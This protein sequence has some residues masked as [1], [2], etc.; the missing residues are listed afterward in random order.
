MT[1]T[2]SRLMAFLTVVAV[3][4]VGVAIGVAVDRSLLR[5]QSDM[6]RERRGGEGGSPFGMMGESQDTAA[7]NRMRGHIVKRLTDDLTLTPAQAQQVDA[8]FATRERQ[9]D[10]LRARVGPRLDSLRDG[11]RLA[12]D[13]VLSPSQ[14]VKAAER[15]AKWQERRRRGGGD[16]ERHSRDER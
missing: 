16:R 13:S 5:R 11:M 1:T 3:L 6:S 2:R 7:R 10:S 12:L 9:L 4:G 15:R 8:I 14:R